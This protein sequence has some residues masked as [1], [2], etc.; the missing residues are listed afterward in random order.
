[1][2]YVPAD[3]YAWPFDGDL[4]A[5]NTALVVIDMQTDFCGKGG[6]ID[7]LGYD[8]SLTRACIEPIS[9]VLGAMRTRAS[10]SSH[11]REGHRP[12]LSDYRPT[13][14]GDR[15]DRAGSAS[16]IPVRVVGCWCEA[17]R[18]GTSFR[19]SR[20]WLVSPSSTSQA[21][22]RSAQPISSSSSDSEESGIWS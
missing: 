12:D 22:G 1:M 20:L 3:P 11:T 7:L 8:I 10:T 19:S 4:R 14:A 15:A 17:S 6:Y 16:A 21:K 18:A 5:E 13:S 9:R 2:K